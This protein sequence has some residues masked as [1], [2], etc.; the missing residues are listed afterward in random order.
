MVSDLDGNRIPMVAKIEIVIEPQQ[1]ARAVLEVLATV[2][3][4]TAEAT[5]THRCPRCGMALVVSP[6]EA[7]TT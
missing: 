3:D 6:P 1:E 5:F 2:V 7:S 4:V